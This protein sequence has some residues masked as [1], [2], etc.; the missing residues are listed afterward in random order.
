MK[1]ELVLSLVKNSAP[2]A[3][4]VTTRGIQT[5]FERWR[6]RESGCEG[7]GRAGR[8]MF[9]FWGSN[10]RSGAVL[11]SNRSAPFCSTDLVNTK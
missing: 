4:T 9:Y 2:G 8:P 7:L 3:I 11:T 1:K 6:D 10:T 5:V